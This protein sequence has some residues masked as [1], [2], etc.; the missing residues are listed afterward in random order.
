MTL[1][2]R[3][4]TVKWTL[5]VILI[6]GIGVGGFFGYKAYA[7]YLANK[8]YTPGQTISLSDFDI[9]VTDATFKPVA[10]PIDQQAVQ[11][12]SG[13][14]AQENCDAQSKDYTWM[15][16]AGQWSH[17]GPSEYN[18]CVRR[19]NSRAAINTYTSENKQLIVNF[20]ITGKHS[21][22]TKNLQIDL[23]PDSGRDLDARVNEL[24]ANQ[25]FANGAQRIDNSPLISVFSTP[26]GPVMTSEAISAYTPYT[27]SDLGGDINPGIV[28]SASISTDIRNSEKSVDVK[29]TYKK[30]GEVAI[31]LVRITK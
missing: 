31:R 10:L 6:I 4:S 30:N 19:N 7:N 11:K 28:R 23:V 9:K 12:Y 18:I 5:L 29:I 15:Q 13:L 3:H 14:T 24:N 27:K 8:I 16:L 25:F 21:V 22:D 2:A 20:V 26:P 1:Q 17:T